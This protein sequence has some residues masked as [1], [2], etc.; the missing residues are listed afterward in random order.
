MSADAKPFAYRI[1]LLTVWQVP[2]PAQPA[3]A[4]SRFHLT[5]PHTGKRY[6]CTSVETLIT[7]LQQ[8]ANDQQSADSVA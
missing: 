3:P 6:G 5:D 8:L 2:S 1:Y 4:E 7:T